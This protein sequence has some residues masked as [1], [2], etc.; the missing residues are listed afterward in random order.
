MNWQ[1]RERGQ[2]ETDGREGKV[3]EIEREGEKGLKNRN[4]ER[5]TKERAYSVRKLDR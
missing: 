5:A 2:K 1:E 3:S 4:R